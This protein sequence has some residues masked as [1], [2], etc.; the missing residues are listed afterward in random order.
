MQQDP[1]RI[2]K[3]ANRRLYDTDQSR[4]I[5]LA[6]LAAIVRAGRRV[7]VVDAKSGDD[8]TR[9]VLVQVILDEQERLDL[10]P[11]DLL[12]HVIRVQG[13]VQAEALSTFLGE[14]L[15]QF[16]SVGEAWSRQLDTAFGSAAEA[17]RAGA[18]AWMEMVTGA[19]GSTGKQPTGAP[20]AD[21]EPA[22]EPQA[23][24]EAEAEADPAEP[25]LANDVA[26]LKAQMAELMKMLGG[27][28][29]G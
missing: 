12:H 5:T 24:A 9:Q 6:E 29:Q 3:Y 7:E 15:Q 21:P 4:Y 23:E 11:I 10:L 13:T 2:K 19:F 1:L 18:N 28:G 27:G 25:R 22:P 17:A 16:L 26:A 14:S 20:D 8:L